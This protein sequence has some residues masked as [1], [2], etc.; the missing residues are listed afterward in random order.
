MSELQK[1]TSRFPTLSPTATDHPPE[2]IE[3]WEEA[4]RV[5]A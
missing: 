1:F 2:V 5:A 3:A 4:R